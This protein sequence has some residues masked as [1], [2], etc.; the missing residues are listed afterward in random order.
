MSKPTILIFTLFYYPGYKA[1]GPIKSIYQ[2]TNSL[3]DEF[4]FKIITSDRDA[5]DKHAFKDV[6][7]NEWTKFENIPIFYY[8]QSRNF[9]YFLKIIKNTKYDAIYLNSLMDK[10]FTIKIL[11]FMYFGLL[12]RKP[13][14]LAPR[15]ECSLGALSIKTFRKII[16]ISLF[17][18]C[19]L[20]KSLKWQASS[21]FEKNDISHLIAFDPSEL[22]I[23]CVAPDISSC[24]PLL[25]NKIN[26][27][28]TK[29]LQICFLSRISKMKNLDY[30]LH[31]LTQ[32]DIPI[33][34][35]IYGPIEDEAYWNK[36]KNIIRDIPN[37]V[38]VIFHDRIP[39]VNVMEKLS[40][41]DLFF[42]P[43]LGENFGHVIAESFLAG[44]P[45]LISDQ[46]PWRNLKNLGVGWDLPLNDPDSF[47]KAIVESA[48]KSSE[49]YINWRSIVQKFGYDIAY[50]PKI[51][52]QNIA[53]FK[54]LIQNKT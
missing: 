13:I 21:Q 36:C 46:T 51:K 31:V 49:D 39:P 7:V 43:T 3:S 50:D 6:T 48:N 2:I 11:L 22:D 32:I 24:N 4:E 54:S 52:N 37:S 10:K 20:L 15:G 19:G 25:L 5:G 34:F 12:K 28:I 45:V 40:Q 35:N 9:L 29:P 17:Q 8:K 53:M 16:Y 41:N 23:I 26:R 27:D 14:L 30:A 38:D 18:I 1:G 42:L 33:V 44:T 47:R